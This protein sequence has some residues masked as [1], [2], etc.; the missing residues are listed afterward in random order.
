MDALREKTGSRS[1]IVCPYHANAGGFYEASQPRQCPEGEGSY[2][3]KLRRHSVRERK[4]GPSVPLTIFHCALHEV[5]FTVYPPGWG[6]WLRVPLVPCSPEGQILDTGQDIF[7]ASRNAAK[8]SDWPESVAQQKDATK[9]HYLG[10]F[11]TQKRH[12]HLGAKLLG[13]H[14]EL[15]AIQSECAIILDLSELELREASKRIRDG[16]TFRRI[17]EE[18]VATLT[19]LHDVTMLLIRLMRTG[20]RNQLWGAP[21]IHCEATQ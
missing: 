17:A 18:G 3:C 7:A 5:Y 20:S 21:I 16:P 2:A 14:P 9:S 15:G 1:P 19:K 10:V 8:R 4:A 6:P 12:I 13:I 11:R